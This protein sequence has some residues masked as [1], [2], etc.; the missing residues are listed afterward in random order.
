[1]TALLDIPT[2]RFL[3]NVRRLGAA[4]LVVSSMAVPSAASAS[5]VRD[6]S[7]DAA[8]CTQASIGAPSIRLAGAV[9]TA[10]AV[11]DGLGW[12][13]RFIL[14]VDA[15]FD[16]RGGVLPFAVPLPAGEELVPTPG[17]AAVTD[18]D[19]VIG[20][21]VAR[22]ALR[23]RTVS[24]SF[25]Q[26]TAPSA[27][28]PIE[29]GAPV[30][31]GTAVQIIETSI[32]DRRIEPA[33]TPLLEKHVGYAA[34][35][36]IS[37]GAREEARRLT[38]VRAK[39]STSPIYVRGDDVHAIGGLKARIVDPRTR[40]RRSAAGVGVAFAGIVGVLVLAARK[41]RDTASVER[42]DALLAS[43]IDHAALAIA[44]DARSKER[45]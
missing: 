16:F 1:M 13:A 3:T 19:R 11:D 34:P 2:I 15:A 35:R 10:R 37:H 29:L 42:A 40:A 26:R 14:D 21:C 7:I 18:G 31:A 33:A 41:L 32:G 27:S 45:S 24:A 4:L 43:E 39:V 20:L 5:D 36:A 23:D 38:D 44:P 12:D 22:E 8:S 30:A 25:V 28:V 9:F 6:A 17:L